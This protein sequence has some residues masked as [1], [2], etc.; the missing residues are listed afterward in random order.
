MKSKRLLAVLLA[1]AMAVTMAACGN[2]T[3]TG[4]STPPETASG[5]TTPS[6]SGANDTSSDDSSDVTYENKVI[7]GNT[8]DLSGD[9][10]YPGWGTSS[11]GA[12]R[13]EEHTSELQSPS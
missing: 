4:S 7:M 12:S 2:D 5:E 6:G 1:S 3:P 11:V 13:S 8:T 9:F 10:R